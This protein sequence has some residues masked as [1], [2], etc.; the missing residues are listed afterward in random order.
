MISAAPP[1]TK[2]SP[3]VK[4]S[5]IILD[6]KFVKTSKDWNGKQKTQNVT[7]ENDT[8]VTEESDTRDTFPSKYHR[9]YRKR[10]KIQ[11]S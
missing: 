4:R 9:R 8:K 5:A 3:Q 10:N 7:G 2:A 11:S 1:K 6:M